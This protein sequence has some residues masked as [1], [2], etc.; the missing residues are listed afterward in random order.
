[1][2]LVLAAIFYLNVNPRM[3]LPEEKQAAL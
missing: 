2:G 3:A 1:L